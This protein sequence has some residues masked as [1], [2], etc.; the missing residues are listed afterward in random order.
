MLVQ[1]RVLLAQDVIFAQSSKLL[2]WLKLAHLAQQDEFLGPKA[3]P[4]RHWGLPLHELAHTDN[5]LLTG[6]HSPVLPPYL[7]G[8][9]FDC[10]APQG[11]A[12]GPRRDQSL[13]GNQIHQGRTTQPA[14]LRRAHLQSSSQSTEVTS[15]PSVK[16]LRTPKVQYAALATLQVLASV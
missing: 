1:S 5:P 16:S 2:E 7:T 3:E 4:P 15:K 9:V 14:C 8:N 6:S 12:L 11:E 13:G 10:A